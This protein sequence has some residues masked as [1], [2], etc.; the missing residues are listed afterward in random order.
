MRLP[1]NSFTSIVSILFVSLGPLLTTHADESIDIP[2]ISRPMWFE[3][4]RRGIAYAFRNEWKNAKED[5]EICLGIRP[6]ATFGEYSE[7]LFARTYGLHYLRDYFPHRERGIALYYLND[8]M[9]AEKEL[10]TSLNMLP[11]SRAKFFL[12]KV[13]RELVRKQVKGPDELELRSRFDKKTLYFNTNYITLEHITIYSPFYISE[14]SVN[15]APYYVDV[16]A[17]E[18]RFDPTE[19]FFINPAKP[20]LFL[21]AKDFAGNSGTWEFDLSIDYQGPAI[22][23]NTEKLDDGTTRFDIFIS[24][25]EE[26]HEVIIGDTTHTF[27]KEKRKRFKTH[28]QLKTK[29]RVRIEAKDKAGNSTRY[30]LRSDSRNYLRKSMNLFQSNSWIAVASSI[31]MAFS[32]GSKKPKFS[33]QN[34]LPKSA[35]IFLT[36]Q[37]KSMENTHEC[38]KKILSDWLYL[39]VQVISEDS[40]IDLVKFYKS[41]SI[42]AP[43]IG[44]DLKIDNQAYSDSLQHI[45]GEKIFDSENCKHPQDQVIISEKVS[46]HSDLKTKTIADQGI[47]KV[48]AVSVKSCESEESENESYCIVK[49]HPLQHEQRMSGLLGLVFIEDKLKKHIDSKSLY[50]DIRLLLRQN[51]DRIEVGPDLVDLESKDR[52]RYEQLLASDHYWHIKGEVLSRPS[53]TK[54]G[55]ELRLTVES[56]SSDPKN[57]KSNKPFNEYLIVTETLYFDRYAAEDRKRKLASLVMDLIQRIPTGHTY[58]IKK[59][60][61]NKVL[62]SNNNLL[63]LKKGMVFWFTKAP[64]NEHIPPFETDLLTPYSLSSRSTESPEIVKGTITGSK[65]RSYEVTISSKKEGKLLKE[66]DLAILF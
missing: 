20:Q 31:P 32:D 51:Q 52:E 16:A 40:E 35:Q 53:K 42:S 2:S 64:K 13:R 17:Q 62:V 25:N 9:E 41:P 39:Q 14:V 65:K 26:L 6:G 3:Y 59:K 11:S 5:F 15:G 33:E 57:D 30:Q 38:N 28:H 46:F 49:E 55:W 48:V 50:K 1:K 18:F 60:S 19:T 61:K 21:T 4:Y 44:P 29:E 45:R 27:E 12:N 63:E 56:K 7:R 66:G 43:I 36:P 24:D 37:L 10:V 22:G 34:D 58:I 54:E 8:L 47:T 23:Y